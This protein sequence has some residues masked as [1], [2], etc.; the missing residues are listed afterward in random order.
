[1]VGAVDP[2]LI[3]RVAQADVHHKNVETLATRV[4]T[5]V[6]TVPRWRQRR[7]QPVLFDEVVKP[8]LRMGAREVLKPQRYR[9]DSAS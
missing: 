8:A 7:R 6:C 1:M 2:A 9:T 5:R 3:E 4:L